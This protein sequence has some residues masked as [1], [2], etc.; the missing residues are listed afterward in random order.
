MSG[1]FDIHFTPDF[2][3]MAESSNPYYSEGYAYFNKPF[4]VRHW[5]RHGKYIGNNKNHER[6]LDK[7]VVVILVDPDMI[8]LR[9]IT[10]DFSNEAK[11]IFASKRKLK[12]FRVKHGS[13][14]AQRYLYGSDWRLNVTMSDIAGNDSPALEVEEKEAADFYPAGPPYIAT[15]KDMHNIVIKWTE[16]VTKV[17]EEFPYL[18]AEMHAYSI[19]AANL[20]L[21]HQL[22]DSMMISDVPANREGWKFIDKM[23]VAHRCDIASNIYEYSGKLPKTLHY[24]QDYAVGDWFFSKSSF[25]TNFFTC[26]TPLL[27]VPPMDIAL[28]FDYTKFLFPNQN[29]GK[30]EASTSR[31]IARYTFT[32][33]SLISILNELGTFFKDNHC[34]G[35]EKTRRDE[36]IDLWKLGHHVEQIFEPSKHDEMMSRKKKSELKQHFKFN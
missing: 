30:K 27:A 11:H 19:A 3:E 8:L 29:Y 10:D 9:P 7:D 32:L 22:V 5:L 12:E 26:E 34:N 23:P 16:F 21:P 2:M 15:A 4:G 33:C 25:P 1:M 24:C 20:K 14:F 6:K 31:D 18:M 35:I 28:K 17:F 13:P 36:S